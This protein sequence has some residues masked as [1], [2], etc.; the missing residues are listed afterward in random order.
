M[1]AVLPAAL[2]LVCAFSAPLCDV[3]H[4]VG[5]AQ[6]PTPYIMRLTQTPRGMAAFDGRT[7]YVS[8]GFTQEG[9]VA[10]ILAHE[11]THA[12][13]PPRLSRGVCVADETAAYQAEKDQLGF[14]VQTF[15]VPVLTTTQDML[16]WITTV[17]DQPA[18]LAIMDCR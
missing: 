12:S 4:R 10:L 6:V 13:Q 3:S 11:L 17:I 7:V 5:Y 1:T 2:A 9:V 16:T 14:I 18:D 15:G 8:D